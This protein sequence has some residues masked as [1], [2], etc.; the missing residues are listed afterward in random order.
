MIVTPEGLNVFPEDVE[1]VLNHLP[2]VR[3]S[4]VVGDRRSRRRRAGARRARRS[5]RARSPT[6]WSG[7]ANGQLA[8]HQRI[9]RSLRLARAGAAADR[10][11]TQ[12][13][14]RRDPRVGGERRRAAPGRRPGPTR[15][16]RSSRGTRAAPI[17]RRH[18]A[19]G[20]RLEL[21]RAGRADGGARRRVPDADRR[22]RVL[23][24]RAICR[25]C[26]RSSNRPATSDVPP[27]EPVEFPVVEPDVAG[28]R[29]P[30]RQPADLDPAARAGRSR[31]CR[32]RGA[33]IS[34]GCDG[35]VMFAANHQS[36]MDTP[37][38]SG[39]A[40]AAAALPGRA[41]HGQGVLQGALLSRPSTAARRGSR[42]A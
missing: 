7:P 1:R 11:H 19:R 13:E 42:T 4:A 37:G 41:R 15:S 29:H 25:S 2:G 16:P 17:S 31:G 6:T 36:H 22:G 39:G 21:A 28:A 33:S 34:S 5:T 30:P 12:A 40:A 38:D 14:A 3:E 18:D 23:P 10:R 26:G 32:S 8:D 27:A 20:A 24:A 35:P 9:R